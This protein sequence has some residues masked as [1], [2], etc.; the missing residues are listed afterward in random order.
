MRQRSES[1]EVGTDAADGR[2]RGGG[3]ENKKGEGRERGGGR[4]A[5][6]EMKTAGRY[7]QRSSGKKIKQKEEGNK[8]R[9]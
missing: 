3:R 4:G 5:E 2:S 1:W 8:E 9:K 7:A 6:S